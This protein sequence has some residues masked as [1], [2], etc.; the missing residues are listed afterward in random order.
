MTGKLTKAEVR[1]TQAT[2]PRPVDAVHEVV[3]QL[4]ASYQ[5]TAS[6]RILAVEDDL[7]GR[8]IDSLA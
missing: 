6:L 4:R 2:S 1:V 5:Y 3:D 7:L 8:V